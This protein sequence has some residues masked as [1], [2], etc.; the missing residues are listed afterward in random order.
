MASPVATNYDFTRL[1]YTH[2]NLAA[3]ALEK[4]PPETIELIRSRLVRKTPPTP[5][6]TPSVTPP[7]LSQNAITGVQCCL[8]ELPALELESLLKEYERVCACGICFGLGHRRPR[9][10]NGGIYVPPGIRLGLGERNHWLLQ[11]A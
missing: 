8:A 3:A 2:A 5:S 10:L 11:R 9:D 4:L 1:P 7:P 6:P